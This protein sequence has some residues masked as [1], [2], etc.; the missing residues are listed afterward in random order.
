MHNVSGS[1][2]GGLEWQV[3]NEK[4]LL[5]SSAANI[6]QR[7]IQ[8][9]CKKDLKDG[10]DDLGVLGLQETKELIGHRQWGRYKL[11]R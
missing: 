11:C 6:R 5:I 1:D 8:S 9:S 10:K 4:L 7:E 2:E 3:I